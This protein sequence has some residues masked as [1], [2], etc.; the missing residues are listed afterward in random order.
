MVKS[1]KIVI[2]LEQWIGFQQKKE[3]LL[4]NEYTHLY[5]LHMEKIRYR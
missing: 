1:G 4:N 5:I 3:M 2:V